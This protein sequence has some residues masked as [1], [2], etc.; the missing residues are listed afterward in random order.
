MKYILQFLLCTSILA[1]NTGK[2][3][4][5][6]TTG[7]AKDKAT[8]VQQYF[9]VTPFI[10]GQLY[11]FKVRGIGPLKY[12]TINGKTDSVWLK[13]EEVEAALSEFL[14]P[15]IDSV[16]M[17]PFFSEKKFLDQTI[18]AYTYTYE[19]KQALPD[20]ITI[21]RWDVL[22]DE[23]SSKVRRIY[24]VKELPNH[25]I[26]QLTWQAGKW[27]KII[28]ILNSQVEKEIKISWDY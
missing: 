26:L 6:S 19:P 4:K 9:P 23:E 12:T 18:A 27:C 21:S 25:S 28:S 1:C 11:D 5:E 7:N 22:I 17:I 13:Q 8:A 10:R 20:S 2:D 15:E 3:N 14:Y 24:I 16:N